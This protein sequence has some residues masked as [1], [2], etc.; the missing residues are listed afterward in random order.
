MSV[1]NNQNTGVKSS[2]V[3]KVLRVLYWTVFAI[4]LVIV[5]VF[6]AFKIVIDKPNVGGQVVIP[7]PTVSVTPGPG[8][9]DPG[10]DQTDPGHTDPGTD[11]PTAPPTTLVLNRVPDVYTCLLVGTDDGNGNADTIMLGVFNTAKKT[12]SLVSIPRDTLVFMN[13]KDYKIN[14]LYA[15][16]GL[17]GIREAITDTLAIPVDF[18]V[19]VDLAAFEEI[20]NEIGGV[21]FTVPQDMEYSDP[22]QDLYID[23]EQGYQL[24][25]GDKAL[26]LVRFRSGYNDQDLGR[27]QVQRQF[28]VAMVKQAVSL[29]NVTKVTSLIEILNQYVVSDM[30]VGNM[31]YFATQAIGMDL[32]SALTSATLPTDW[33]YP[34]LQV[35]DGEA[36]DLINSLGI[37]QEQ[38]PAEALHIR[39]K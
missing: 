29:S 25:D 2:P 24:L 10:T 23:L 28:L 38:V 5:V 4:S 26:Q 14:A 37:Y 20:V 27:V 12:A 3:M 8:Q 31:V 7:P 36:L 35:R 17:E 39:H 18:H 19:A 22:E 1:K 32:N 9:T 34:T 11:Q 30:P 6:A 15:Y 16:Y 13:G 33:V 21:W